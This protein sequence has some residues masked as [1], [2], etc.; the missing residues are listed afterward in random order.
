MAINL[1]Q[2]G[3]GLCGCVE[4]GLNQALNGL[5]N[6]ANNIIREQT[7]LGNR[8]LR[9]AQSRLPLQT[10]QDALSDIQALQNNILFQ[11]EIGFP[12][13]ENLGLSRT[14]QC[15]S[16]QITG[17]LNGYLSTIDP[18]GY[19]DLVASY[20]AR[21]EGIVNR[22]LG[23][24]SFNLD[25]HVNICGGSGAGFQAVVDAALGSIHVGASGQFNIPNFTSGIG[26]DSTYRTVFDQASGA[27]QSIRRLQ[28]RLPDLPS[29]GGSG[30][31]LFG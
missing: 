28:T 5:E 12:V 25:A 10:I 24:F 22:I 15:V 3:S 11:A 4:Q 21:V 26:L 27:I 8:L 18:F 1:Q 16:D 6:Q 31:D 9:Q 2:I 13:D 23:G 19:I 20:A 17:Q 29:F 30:F 7:A 14:I